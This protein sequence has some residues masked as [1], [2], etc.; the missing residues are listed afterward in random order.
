MV[1]TILVIGLAMFMGVCMFFVYRWVAEPVKL[2]EVKDEDGLE[3]D[4]DALPKAPQR[5]IAPDDDPEFLRRLSNR[6]PDDF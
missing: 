6:R 3:I 1:L 5:Q 2:D 4:W